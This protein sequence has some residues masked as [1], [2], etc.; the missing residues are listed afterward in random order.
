[1]AEQIPKPS[2]IGRGAAFI[3]GAGDNIDIIEETL[4]GKEITHVTSM[5]LYQH[6]SVD[7]DINHAR[8]SS[9][10]LPRWKGSNASQKNKERIIATS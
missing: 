5:V 4:D 6:H 10:I 9:N 3:Q 2:N 8:N 7:D 1:M